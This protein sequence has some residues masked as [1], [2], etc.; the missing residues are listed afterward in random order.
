MRVEP[1]GGAVD[2]RQ[3]DQ[4]RAPAPRRAA[5]SRCGSRGGVRTSVRSRLRPRCSASRWPRRRPASATS[6]G[7]SVGIGV[8]SGGG[9]G[10][11]AGWQRRQRP[12]FLLREVR[13]DDVLGDRR[14]EVAVLVVLAE[15]HAGDLRVVR[16]REEHEPAVVAQV[17]VRCRAPPARPWFEI[18]CAVPVLPRR[19]ARECARGRRCRRRSPP[20]TARRAAPPASP[21]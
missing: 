20:S 4:R 15:D 3:A 11:G 16:R 21:A 6:I 2:L 10:T 14:A 9:A 19:R 18:T 13:L 8:G 12:P 5:P 7:G 17:A 1:A